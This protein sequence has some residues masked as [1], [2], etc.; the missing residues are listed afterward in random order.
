MKQEIQTTKIV[1]KC[2]FCDKEGVRKCEACG[3]DVCYDHFN[4]ISRTGRDYGDEICPACMEVLGPLVEKR[5]AV[6][7]NICKAIETLGMK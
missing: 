2:D 7:D 4:T 6:E 3:K 5:D 1:V